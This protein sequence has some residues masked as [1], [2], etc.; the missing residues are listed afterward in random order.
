MHLI[1]SNYI[2]STIVIMYSGY[3]AVYY[4]VSLYDA[5]IMETWLICAIV[6]LIR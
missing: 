5:N 3:L 1:T 4:C 6:Y 2:E